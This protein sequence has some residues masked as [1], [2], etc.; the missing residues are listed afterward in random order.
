MIFVAAC[1]GAH[2]LCLPCE[3]T[4]LLVAATLATVLALSSPRLLTMRFV[5]CEGYHTI[6]T[7]ETLSDW[8][9]AQLSL[10]LTTLCRTTM[11]ACWQ[12]LPCWVVTL[13]VFGLVV[14]SV[15]SPPTE[16]IRALSFASVTRPIKLLATRYQRH[17]Y[18]LT[19]RS[20]V[21]G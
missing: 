19:V 2:D 20:V 11:Q 1:A 21:T 3:E 5:Y 6:E 17:W 4:L 13:R 7:G 14:V 18:C 15:S 16:T 10:L 8:H 12:P 9:S